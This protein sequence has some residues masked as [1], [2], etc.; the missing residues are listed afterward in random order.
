M[1]LRDYKPKHKLLE[2]A[3]DNGNLWQMITST[4]L[5]NYDEA[6]EKYGHMEI[7]SIRNYDDT[8]TTS[9]IVKVVH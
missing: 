7:A 2:L 3:F 4:H 6:V 8:K 5:I 1:K 9:I